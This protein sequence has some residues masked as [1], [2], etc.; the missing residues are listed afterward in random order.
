M[1]CGLISRPHLFH[2]KKNLATINNECCAELPVVNSYKLKNST[3]Y[4]SCKHDSKPVKQYYI[5]L[6][7]NH[8]LDLVKGRVWGTRLCSPLECTEI[9]LVPRLDSYDLAMRQSN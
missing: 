9:N 7:C 3:V 8:W 4:V 1:Q 2:E 5:E 6:I